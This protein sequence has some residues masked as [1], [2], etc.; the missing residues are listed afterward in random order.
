MIATET[1]KGLLAVQNYTLSPMVFPSFTANKQNM[2]FTY[3]LCPEWPWAL[4]AVDPP[5]FWALQ[6]PP[7]ARSSQ[8]RES[9]R[10]QRASGTHWCHD[11][12]EKTT[13]IPSLD[14]Q[15]APRAPHLPLSEGPKWPKTASST[16]PN[17]IKSPSIPIIATTAPIPPLQALPPS[18]TLP[19]SITTPAPVSAA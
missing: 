11:L 17:I 6:G 18:P 13:T 5:L 15:K 12:P 2:R 10:S 7:G 9:R 4:P 16:S 1:T 19:L 8:P 14:C 3:P